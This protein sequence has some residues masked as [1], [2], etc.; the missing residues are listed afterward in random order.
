MLLR[1]YLGHEELEAIDREILDRR[2]HPDKVLFVSVRSTLL[3]ASQHR[4]EKRRLTRKAVHDLIQRY[5]KRL[6]LPS[7]ELHP[8]AMRHLF[9]TELTEENVP[10]LAVADLM[11]HAD[12][13]S[14]DVYVHLAVRRKADLID[15]HGPLGR[16]NTPVRDLLKRLPPGN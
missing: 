11:G 14:T 3:D 1:V 7:S 4:G 10:S 9:G 6:G 13:K 12:V 5:G 15:K 2:S 16:I 8:H